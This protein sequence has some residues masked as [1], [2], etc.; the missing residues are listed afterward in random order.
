MLR[1][2]IRFVLLSFALLLFTPAHSEM[3]FS[4]S[5][6]LDSFNYDLDNI[7]LKL[8]KLN[9]RWQLSPSGDGKLQI[10]QLKAKR[11][12]VTIRDD[13][14]KS[15]DS[16]LPNRINLPFSIIIQQADIA[17][18]VI[19]TTDK[20]QTLNNVKFSFEGNA[21]TLHLKLTYADTPWGNA[22]AALNLS[23]AQPFPLTGEVALKQ[24]VGNTPYDVKALLSGDLKT[25][26]FESTAWLAQQNGKLAILQDRNI[27]NQTAA[28]IV[29]D[30]QLSLANDY[31]IN[32]NARLTELQPERLGNYP[33]A[34]LN[35]DLN[36]QGTLQP[37]PTSKLEIIARNSQWQGQPLSASANLL[38]AGTK[39]QHLDF[40]ANIA[41]SHIQANGSLGNPDSHM[42]WEANLPDLTVFGKEYAGQ[43][44]TEGTLDGTF[45]NPALHFNLAAQKLKLANDLTIEKLEGQATL[46]AGE[47]GKADGDFTASALTY[48]QHAPINAHATLQGTRTSHQMVVSTQGQ[49]LQFDSILKGGLTTDKVSA[50]TYWQG[51]LQQLA[52]TGQTNLKLSA[53]VPLRIDSDSVTLEQAT[54]QMNQGRVYIN[55][56]QV[57]NN[58][59]ISQG[60]LEQLSLK[61]LPADLLHLPSTLQGNPVF[62]GKW[63]I[64]ANETLNGKL[65][66]W[67]EAGDFTFRTAN[68]TSDPLGLKE[69]KLDIAITNNQVMLTTKVEGDQLGKLNVQL[70][71]TLTKADAGFALLASAPLALNATAQLQ[72]LAWLPLPTSLMDADI[73]G[74]LT[75]TVAGDGTLDKP[76]LSGNVTGTNLHLA[77]P[78]EGV[79]L[80]NGSL[81]AAFQNDQLLIKQASWQGGTGSLSVSGLM[82]LDNGK[83]KINLDWTANK[84]TIL[85]RTDR[86]LI[87][88]GSGQTL[89][90]DGVLSIQGKFTVDKGLIELANEDAPVLGDDVVILGQSTATKEQTL[91]ILLNGLHIDLGNDFTLRGRGLDAELIGG[92]TMTGLTQYH[93]HTEGSI[94]V[95]KGTYMA[96]GQV[97]NIE[98]GILNFSGPM[99]NPGLNIRAMR[100]SKPIN[101]GVEITGSA[102]I[103][104]TQLVSDPNVPE[105]EKLSWLVLGHGMDQAGKNDYGMLSLAAGVLLSQGQSVPLQTQLARAA[106]LD[107]FSF[108]GGDAESASLVFGKRLTSKLY[109]SYVKSIA[110]LLDV[111][112][113]TFTI[114]PRWSLRAEAGTESAVDVLYTF[115]FK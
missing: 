111:A 40:E 66:L 65:S 98:R 90:A 10:A 86:L 82:L 89:L 101:A 55:S 77:I 3:S 81:Q 80:S 1:R 52:I 6:S 13:A 91:L 58:K 69:A 83:P 104:V 23:T 39:I 72:T 9:A 4:A 24:L 33:P 18:V 50:K 21:K 27:A 76:N 84:F 2:T 44:H 11:L 70:G 43:A 56:L 45:D 15:K 63:D 28:H 100:N 68:S 37:T 79:S 7:H 93:P 49:D 17:E 74:Q 25:L 88:S 38:L 64:N 106:G 110:G 61:D 67:R 107:E 114:S 73:D 108:A 42:T 32:I 97:L 85:S 113:L 16:P 12:T 99:D 92:L 20:R 51:A 87:L 57:T 46:T 8:E 103:P 94:Q 71:T 105:S 53:P 5:S 54:L 34:L 102:F 78:S 115:S 35:F 47:N 31:P 19:I 26:H 96:Y 62:S 36:L 95:K 14:S 112:R 22:T 75:L 48:G 29:A 60:H 109:L 59:L 41:T 30:G